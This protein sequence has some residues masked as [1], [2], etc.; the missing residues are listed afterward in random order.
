MGMNFL[1]AGVVFP[2]RGA[3]G[4]RGPMVSPPAV[5]VDD[6]VDSGILPG[7]EQVTTNDVLRRLPQPQQE[8]LRRQ[9]DTG[10]H[11]DK[12]TYDDWLGEN[13]ADLP[14]Q[15]RLSAMQRAARQAPRI[16]IGADPNLLP[17]ENSELAESRR[18]AGL[19]L[20]EGREPKQYSPEQR[21]R[22]SRNVHNPEVPMTTFG[23]TFTH[24]PDGSLSSRA[25][26]PKALE[27][28]NAIAADPEQGRYSPSHIAALAIAY[29]ID[30]KK[31]G[32]DLD[33][34]RQDVM[35]E[36]ARHQRLGKT[37]ATVET[38]GGGYRYA[39]KDADGNDAPIAKHAQ[40]LD[41]RRRARE[42]LEMY[43]SSSELTPEE[44]AQ[45]KVGIPLPPERRLAL[46]NHALEQRNI[47]VRQTANNYNLTRMMNNP[48][49]RQ[50]AYIRSLQQA[51]QSGDPLQVAQIHESFGNRPAAQEAMRLAALQQQAA[52]GLAAAQAQADAANKPDPTLG[53]QME[54]E[55]SDAMRLPT[56]EEQREGIRSVVRR[57]PANEGLADDAIEQKTTRIHMSRIARQNP[58]DP[59]VKSYLQSLA[60]DEAAF[61]SFATEVYG[62]DAARQ[63]LAQAQGTPA[64]RGAQA[65]AGLQ[66]WASDTWNWLQGATGLGGAAPGGPSR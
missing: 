4:T 17:G 51:V 58:N 55:Y 36:D 28:A 43:G 37:Y 54:R 62:A 57:N 40:T 34:L 20:P 44:R 52:A 32:N 1:P 27:L 15:R 23:G 35:R 48:T 50:G 46:R 12:M 6:G 29:G 19:P 61:M 45:L 8:A 14:P 2:T 22:M 59:R 60:G 7:E 31:Y 25:P 65:T 26:N 11:A 66:N 38:G 18:A 41:D 47:S 24:N 39:T 63:M 3:T 16:P 30:A 5:P 53:A 13:F 9:Y 33:L 64:Q 10:G 49:Q 21:Q 42:T 56:Y